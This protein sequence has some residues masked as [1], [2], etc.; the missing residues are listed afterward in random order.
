MPNATHPAGIA[1]VASDGSTVADGRYVLS[2]VS[3]RVV[4]LRRLAP[5]DIDPTGADEGNTIAINGSSTAVYVEASVPVILLPAGSD[6]SDVPAGTPV[7]TIV[8]VKA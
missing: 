6:A 8:L 4:E 2:V 5:G 1:P 3:G 7:G